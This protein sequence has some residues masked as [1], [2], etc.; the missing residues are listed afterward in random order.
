MTTDL[1]T[2]LN[3]NNNGTEALIYQACLSSTSGDSATATSDKQTFLTAYNQLRTS[4][5]QPAVTIQF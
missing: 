3:Q 4:V 5:G 1:A 2:C